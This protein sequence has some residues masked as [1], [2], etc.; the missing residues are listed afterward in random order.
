MSSVS[1][2]QVPGLPAHPSADGAPPDPLDE[3][4]AAVASRYHAVLAFDSRRDPALEARL[5]L[6]EV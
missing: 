3:L 6:I 2:L 5:R 4:P 1:G